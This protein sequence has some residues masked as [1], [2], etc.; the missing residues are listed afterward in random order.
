MT[1]LPPLRPRPDVIDFL[2]TRRSRPAKTLRAPAPDRDAL[3]PLLAAALRVPDHGKLEPWR[4]IVLGRGALDALAGLTA[5]LGAEREMDPDKLAKGQ[6]QFADA[7][8]IVAV[9]AAPVASDKIPEGEQIMS[10]GAVCLSLCNVAQAAGWGANWLTGWMATDR[11]WLDDGLGCAPH[12][13]VAG[14]VVLGTEGAPPPERPR[15]DLAAKVEWR[16]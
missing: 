9:V 5:R 10:A 13:T 11:T 16:A 12:E 4:L 1:A 3:A 6:A 15:P 2:A 14:F 7:P 8:L